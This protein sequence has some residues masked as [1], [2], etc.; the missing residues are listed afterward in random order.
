MFGNNTKSIFFTTAVIYLF[1]T[2]LN[3][4]IF[5]IMVFENQ[6]DLIAKNAILSSQHT[7]SSLKY[8]IDNIVNN[9][10]LLN[11]S[12][13]NLILKEA[14][15]LNIHNLTLYTEG[16]KIFVEVVEN[17]ITGRESADMDELRLIN[18]AITRQGFEDKLFYHDVDKDNRKI[19]LF[20]PFVFETENIG[21]AG[22]ELYMSGVDKQMGYLYRQCVIIGV[23][24]A[25][26][27]ILFA[28]LFIKMIILP[29]KKI[30]EATK[31]IAKGDLD[32]RVPK[33]GTNE[34]GQLASSFN[35]MSVALK[36]MSNEA[37]ESNPLT[38]LPGNI[39]IANYINK[40]LNENQKICVLYC[41]LDNFKAYN[42]KY[43]FT[44]GDDA[45]LYTRDCLLSVSKR[46][47]VNNVFVGHEGGDDF[48]MVCPYEYWEIIAKA[49][50]TTFDRGI[51]QFY[52]NSDAKNGYIDSVNRMGVRQ[53]FPIMSVSVAVVTN[54]NRPFRRHAEIIQVAAEVKSYV[55]TIDGSCYAID[56]RTGSGKPAR[57][58]NKSMQSKMT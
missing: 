21:V 6:L 2:V 1:L 50:I 13:I 56:R 16:G 17:N 31:S 9:T 25:V 44:R 14:T 52:N 11:S 30:N 42:D 8:R 15:T 12:N 27:H 45:L 29:I 40:N 43:G 26:V 47:D 39:S 49:L 10:G 38:G 37:K 19:M 53:R 36:R 35:E 58:K 28:F 33:F 41:D 54:L 34:F 55:K 3:V 22:I 20:I 48:V 4:T 5:I 46:R 32:I 51:Y 23:L 57:I 18:M 7:A 24:V